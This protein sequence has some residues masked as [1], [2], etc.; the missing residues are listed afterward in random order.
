MLSVKLVRLRKLIL[1]CHHVVL[2]QLF[3]HPDLLNPLLPFVFHPFG[4]FV[5]VLHQV[6]FSVVDRLQ[7]FSL[8]PLY[9]SFEVPLVL[10]ELHLHL[11]LFL[12]RLLELE[13]EVHNLSAQIGDLVLLSIY[14][15]GELVFTVVPAVVE[16]TELP[17][18]RRELVNEGVV[19]SLLPCKLY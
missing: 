1:Q 4:P 18:R 9:L 2:A 13:L 3:P 11:A 12:R 17:L 8:V 15:P 19:P 6:V 16:L 14:V 5:V 10:L 7:R